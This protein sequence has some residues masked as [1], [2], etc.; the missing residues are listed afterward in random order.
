[1]IATKTASAKEIVPGRALLVQTKWRDDRP[2]S[3]LNIYAP[4]VNGGN[5]DKAAKFFEKIKMYFKE[6]TGA[7]KPD[8]VMGDFNIVT[9]PIDRLPMRSDPEKESKP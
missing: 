9:E 8:V 6:H 3:I 7:R 1:M 5:A 4:N 2:L